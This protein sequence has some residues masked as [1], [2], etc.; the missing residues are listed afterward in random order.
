MPTTLFGFNLTH[1]ELWGN[2]L[3]EYLLTLAVFIGCVI[4]FKIFQSI[5]IHRLKKLVKK[6]KTDIDDTLLEIVQSLRPKFYFLISFYIALNFLIVHHI[7]QKTIEVILIIWIIYQIIKAV[8]ILIEFIA[9][10]NTDEESEGETKAAINLISK[11]ASI[12]LWALGLLLVLSNLG[13]NITSLIAGLGIGGIAVALALQN[14]L[15]DLFSSFAIYF[16]KPFTIGDFIIVGDKMGEVEKIG[17]KTTRIK[18]IQGEE[19]IISNQELTSAQ[20][21]NFKKMEERRIVLSLSVLYETPGAKLEKIP[22]LIQETIQSVTKTR[23]DRAHF[24]S[25]GDSALIFE[26]VYYVES[27]EY[28]D[29]M[30]TNQEIHFKLKNALDKE[31][32]EFAYPTQTLYLNK[33]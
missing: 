9:Q 6:T 30:D 7:I 15:S 29:Y 27:G 18:S 8:Q 5:I 17:I 4:I 25:F 28:L 20:I 16:D 19:L 10:K 12:A 2:T 33:S 11:L 32:I 26:A 22:N 24:K 21:Q 3:D 14:I 13:V 1:Y 23:F 31:K